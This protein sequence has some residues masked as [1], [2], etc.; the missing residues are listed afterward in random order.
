[1]FIISGCSVSKENLVENDEEPKVKKTKKNNMSELLKFLEEKENKKE[2][3]R[4]KRH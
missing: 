1:M 2:N 3:A 4:S